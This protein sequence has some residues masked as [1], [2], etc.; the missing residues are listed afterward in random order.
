MNGEGGSDVLTEKMQAGDVKYHQTM[1]IIVGRKNRVWVNKL[2][3][4]VEYM[5]AS[6]STLRDRSKEVE[7]VE[8]RLFKRIMVVSKN[9]NL[10]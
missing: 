9:C 1:K 8:S 10:I 2:V 6:Y 7:C 4:T 3:L 5:I